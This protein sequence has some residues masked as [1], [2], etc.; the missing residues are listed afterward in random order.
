MGSQFENE[1]V[2][3]WIVRFSILHYMDTDNN[4]VIF[5]HRHRS[6]FVYVV[7]IL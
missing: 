3:Y 4:L 2:S 5:C 7:F 6:R 1:S